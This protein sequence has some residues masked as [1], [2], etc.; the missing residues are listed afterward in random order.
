MLL[1][2][3]TCKCFLPFQLIFI[4][5]FYFHLAYFLHQF[6]DV[7]VTFDRP[8]YTVDESSSTVRICFSTT[9]G[10]PDR[11]ITVTIQPRQLRDG[12]PCTDHPTA[13]GM[14]E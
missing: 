5:L 1:V 13:T 14:T 9:A 2:F 11:D 10:H 4:G 6:V 12:D 7:P 8:S 3:H